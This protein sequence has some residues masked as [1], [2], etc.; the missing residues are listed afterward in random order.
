M[1]WSDGV[2]FIELA[3]FAGFAGW[4]IWRVR[5]AAYKRDHRKAAPSDRIIKTLRIH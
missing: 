4:I 1:I 5:N 3:I 2:V